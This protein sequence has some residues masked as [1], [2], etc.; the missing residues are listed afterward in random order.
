MPI[1]SVPTAASLRALIDKVL[2]SDA[3]F[4]AFC[5]DHFETVH[6]RFTSSMEHQQKV[7]LLLQHANRREVLEYLCLRFP[8]ESTLDNWHGGMDWEHAE[9]RASNK[10]QRRYRRRLRD[11][12]LGAAISDWIRRFWGSL[13]PEFQRL[14]LGAIVLLLSGYGF[15]RLASISMVA[16]A[17]PN[18]TAGYQRQ[19]SGFTKVPIGPIIDYMLQ[20]P[21]PDGGQPWVLDRNMTGPGS[22]LRSPSQQSTDHSHYGAF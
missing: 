5:F 22:T 4:D 17:L 11:I 6:R 18:A 7:T 15:A 20:P 10:T 16:S 8:K 12:L 9:A 2:H 1:H 21:S 13:T 19:R 14:V 3:D